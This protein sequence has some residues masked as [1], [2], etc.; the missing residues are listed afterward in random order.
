[1]SWSTPTSSA[2]A[3]RRASG[4]RAYNALRRDLAAFRRLDV[5]QLL[6]KYGGLP[7]VQARIARELGVSESVVSRD[8]KKLLFEVQVCPSCGSY[9]PRSRLSV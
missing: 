5:A 6:F 1:M 3:F 8:R 7:G 2:E 9:R 4:R